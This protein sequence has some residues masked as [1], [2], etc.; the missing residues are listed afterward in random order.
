MK[1]LASSVLFGVW[2]YL[3]HFY[4]DYNFTLYLEPGV[5]SGPVSRPAALWMFLPLAFG[6]YLFVVAEVER[7]RGKAARE[8]A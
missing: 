4:Q 6:V 3:F 1:Y 2:A 5:S 8:A 7:I